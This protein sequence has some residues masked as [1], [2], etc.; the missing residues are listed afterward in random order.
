MPKAGLNTTKMGLNT[1]FEGLNTP[2]MG[3]KPTHRGPKNKFLHMY[4][5]RK[6]ALSTMAF[7]CLEKGDKQS[8]HLI[9][10]VASVHGVLLC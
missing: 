9:V 10:L 7:F 5:A 1:F 6:T 2:N 8:Q 4:G 3:L